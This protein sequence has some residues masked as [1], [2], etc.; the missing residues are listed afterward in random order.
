MRR[1][2][3][4]ME[5]TKAENII[6][7]VFEEDKNYI[8]THITGVHGGLS[9][10]GYLT[11]YL[12]E[13]TIVHSNSEEYIVADNGSLKMVSQDIANEV[14]RIVKARIS[15]DS[16]EIPSIIEWLQEKYSQFLQIVDNKNG[17]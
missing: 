16:K 1:R 10:K 14:R 15:I 5:E 6:K 9:P 17:V 12:F 2:G 13:D 4:N 7:I 8:E 11:A 3:A